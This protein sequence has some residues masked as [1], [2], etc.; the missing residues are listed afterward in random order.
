[1]TKSI[2]KNLDA[3]KI[4]LSKPVCLEGLSEDGVRQLVEAL[5]ITGRDN[6]ENVV[7]SSPGVQLFFK[8]GADGSFEGLYAKQGGV[9][10]VIIPGTS[11]KGLNVFKGPPSSGN[12][13]AGWEV[14]V[15]L[16]KKYLNQSN[17][18]TLWEIF[19]ASRVSI[20]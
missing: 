15:E 14:E 12:P 11:S 17:D 20:I 19:F 1:M 10:G 18:Q 8:F 9:S 2:S 5:V 4:A 16:T 7:L 6:P 13:G 3:Y